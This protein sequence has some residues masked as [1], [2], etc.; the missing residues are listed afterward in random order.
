MALITVLAVVTLLLN[1][2]PAAAQTVTGYDQFSTTVASYVDLH[3]S[4]ES[5]LDKGIR[6]AD[7]DAID[8]FERSL[9]TRISALR[10]QA[11]A[12]D[13]LAPA[14]SH[15]RQ[16]VAAEIA[17]PSGPAILATIEDENVHGVRLRVNHRYPPTLPRVTMPSRLLARLPVLPPELE[18]RFL[19]R[20]LVLVDTHAALVVDLLPDV[21]PAP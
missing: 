8:K 5:G 2:A 17:S 3:R 15:I 18:Y 12:G 21:L 4:A 11:T 14:A 9:A 20:S 7:P 16:V 19:G 1:L 6:A 10:S 13:L